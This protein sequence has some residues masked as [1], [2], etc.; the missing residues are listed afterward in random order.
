MSLFL[1][2]NFLTLKKLKLIISFFYDIFLGQRKLYE[3]FQLQPT[4]ILPLYIMTTTWTQGFSQNICKK[5]AKSATCMQGPEV[6][7]VYSQTWKTTRSAV[8]LEDECFSYVVDD[9]WSYHCIFE[10]NKLWYISGELSVCHCLNVVTV[11]ESH[12]W[13]HQQDCLLAMS[14]T[15]NGFISNWRNVL[16]LFHTQWKPFAKEKIAVS[17][18]FILKY[19]Y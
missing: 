6:L 12:M 18:H 4:P 14:E 3:T 16:V 17:C 2:L 10:W 5:A 8:Y 7:P 19:R 1:K 13:W 11:C 9:S 15:L